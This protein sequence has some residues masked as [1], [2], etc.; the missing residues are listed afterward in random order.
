MVYCL[1]IKV[2]G[3]AAFW[4]DEGPFKG[5]SYE[6]PVFIRTKDRPHTQLCYSDAIERLGVGEHFPCRHIWRL[7]LNITRVRFLQAE[8]G[9][10][11]F[12]QRVETKKSAAA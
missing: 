9:E 10:R 7:A 8:G 11:R 4:R 5:P 3:P 2:D 1:Y 6:A 12:R